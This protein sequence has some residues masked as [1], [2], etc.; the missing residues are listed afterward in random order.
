[1]SRG[2]CILVL[3]DDPTERD[4]MEMQLSELLEPG[5]QLLLAADGMDA[6]DKISTI[7]TPSGFILDLNMPGTIKGIDVLRHIR[8][9]PELKECPVFIFSSSDNPADKRRCKDAGATEFI[10]KPEDIYDSEATMAR[11]VKICRSWD[12]GSGSNEDD[13]L[14]KLLEDLNG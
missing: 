14:S 4:I 11:L 5:E 9:I 13:S 6:V 1:M 7:Q 3:E 12:M 10:R 8:T 2:V